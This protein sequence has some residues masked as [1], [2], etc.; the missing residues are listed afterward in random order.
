MIYWEKRRERPLAQGYV[1]R[2]QGR[3]RNSSKSEEMQRNND[4]AKLRMRVELL[5][6][7]LLRGWKEVKYRVIERFR[8]TYPVK[9]MCEVFGVPRS[10]HYACRK[11]MPGEQ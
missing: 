2:S 1:H 3:P 9:A 10:G 8:S 11:K 5:R 7:L 6:N 4:L